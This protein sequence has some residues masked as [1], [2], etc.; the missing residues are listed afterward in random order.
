MSS[1][2]MLDLVI[3]EYIGIDEETGASLDDNLHKCLVHECNCYVQGS[4]TIVSRHV[5]WTSS[6]NV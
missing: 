3:D 2:K 1:M 5:S 4:K 6:E